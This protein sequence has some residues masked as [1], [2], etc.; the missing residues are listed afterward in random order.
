MLS[1]LDGA[2]L[3]VSAVEGVQAQTRVL[4][5]ALRRLAHPDADLR[6]QDRPARARTRARAARAS[7]RTLTPAS[8]AMG[9][10]DGPGTRRRPDV[11]ADVDDAGFA[12]RL[13]DL[14][15][16]H[17]DALLAAYVARRR[18]CARPRLRAALA[19]QTGRGAGAP[20]VLRLGD[21]R[22]RRRRADRRPHR[23]AA[24]RRG[25]RR[26]PALRH[27]VQGRARARPGRRSPT[28]GCSPARCGSA[29]G[30]AAAG[31]GGEGHRR[32]ASSTAAAAAGTPAVGAGQIAKLLGPRRTSASATRSACPDRRRPATSSPRRRWRPSSC[33]RP[34][35]RPGRAAR[36][37][38]PARRAGPADQPAAGRRPAG[39]LGVA[40]RR[41]AEGG[42]PGDAGRRVRRRGRLPG[43]DHDL[44]RAGRRRRRGRRAASARSRT[45]SWPR[46]GCGSSRRRAGSGV[47]FR[48][49]GRAGV[50][51]AGVLQGG[52]GDGARD[53][54]AGT[55]RLAGHRLRGDHDPLRLLGPAEPRPRHVRQEHVQHRG[56]LPQ[57]DPAGA[58]GRAAPGRHPGVRAD[59]PVP[60][61][62]PGRHARPGAAGA[63]RARRGA[64][65]LDRRA[66]RRTCWRGRSRRR[67]CTRCS[68]SCRR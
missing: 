23:A 26:R 42:H 54:A 7:P 44:R 4:M 47:R 65:Q 6:Q 18:A 22:R 53:A 57:P 20:G 48:L 27:R 24:G 63:G 64:P 3:V 9:A 21:H 62:G 50:D 37:A 31:R 49:G 1:V 34:G 52:R 39:D 5:R 40:L 14:L 15:A 56:G 16:E 32:S 55:A 33:P 35:R 2:V 45:R 29:T 60:A 11:P 25:R 61:G 13:L 8:C 38:H 46:S 58:D 67:G 30:C 59:A 10:V 12:A 68:S 19:A 36:R 43:D 28:S 41:G 66:A 17:D 51:A